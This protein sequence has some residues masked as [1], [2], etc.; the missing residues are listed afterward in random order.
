MKATRSIAWILLAVMLTLSVLSCGKMKD[1]E[2][3]KAATSTAVTTTAEATSDTSATETA[4]PEAVAPALPDADYKKEDFII[5]V[6]ANTNDYRSV[7]FAATEITGS[8]VN[9]AVYTRNVA[10]EDRY[11]VELVGL[12]TKS[13]AKALETSVL[14]SIHTYDFALLRL[15]DAGGLALKGLLMDLNTVPNLYLEGA[16]WDQNAVSDLSLANR[17]YMVT[18]DMNINDKDMTWCMFFDK[19]LAEEHGLPDLYALASNKEWTFEKFG[20]L[21]QN[22][23]ADLNGDGVYDDNDRYGHVTVYARSTIAYMYSMDAM[24]FVKDENDLPVLTEQNAKL[25]DAYEVARSLFFTDNVCHDIETMPTNGYANRWRRSEAMFGNK[26]ILFYAEAMQNAE[27][28]RDFSND[29]GILPI[30]SAEEGVYGKHMV[31]RESY[32][33]VAP[34]TLGGSAELT[35]RAGLLLEAIQRESTDTILPA[36]Y[37]TALKSKFSRD[38][39]SSDMIDIIFA[40]RYYDIGAYYDW[41]D[42]TDAWM[43]Q[44]KAGNESVASAI[45]AQRKVTERALKECVAALTGGTT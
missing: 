24:I 14:A 8:V 10:I 33:T 27:R 5:L 12:V 26:Q 31:W 18:G 20:T 32:V 37:E 3:T 39:S 45:K 21:C 15:M 6:N 41:G 7:E 35:D 13:E 36:Y 34:L 2:V 44:G 4:A 22:V 9:D 40:N 29:F 19:G 28:F 17:L 25:F 43:S 38:D 23:S 1:G 16:W 11:N 30:P 42:M